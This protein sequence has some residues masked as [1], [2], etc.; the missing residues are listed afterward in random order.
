MIKNLCASVL[1]LHRDQTARGDVVLLEDTGIVHDAKHRHGPGGGAKVRFEARRMRFTE[2]A[3]EDEASVP[4]PAHWAE[5][6]A[7]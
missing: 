3:R 2:R 7:A 4:V 5:R 6:E 1:L